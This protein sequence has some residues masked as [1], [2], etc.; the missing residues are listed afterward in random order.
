MNSTINKLLIHRLVQG[1]TLFVALLASGLQAQ[2]TTLST[3]NYCL[4]ALKGEVLDLET[5]S[6]LDS[7]KIILEGSDG[8]EGITYTDTSGKFEFLKIKKNIDYNIIVSHKGYVNCKGHESTVG[9]KSSMVFYH[10]YELQPLIIEHPPTIFIYN[11]N[12][13]TPYFADDSTN[14]PDVYRYIAAVMRDNPHITILCEGYRDSTETPTISNIRAQLFK[15]NLVRSGVQE[16]RIT[17]SDEGVFPRKD[18][19][20]FYM[21]KWNRTIPGMRR[22]IEVS[23]DGTNYKAK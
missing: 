22:T 8:S 9:K 19:P 13:T 10:Q 6:P 15:E 18:I 1:V 17:V 20:M 12:D 5:G 7:T 16:D 4:F 23:V 21:K 14:S 2:D 3:C 11:E